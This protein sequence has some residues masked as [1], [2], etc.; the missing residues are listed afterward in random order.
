MQGPLMLKKIR[1]PIRFKILITLLGIISI[2]VG[3]ITFTMANLFHTDK[4][5]YVRD[6]TSI[7]ATNLAEESHSLLQSYR[8]RMVVFSR[9]VAQRDLPRNQKNLLVK[10]LFEDF[11][12][13][14][15]ISFYWKG[16]ELATAYDEI[17]L[18]AASL[19]RDDFVE[20]REANPVEE[21]MVSGNKVM[22]M[23]STLSNLLP[24]MN[25]GLSHPGPDGDGQMIVI[26]TIRLNKLIQITKRS[27]VF[28]T[29]IINSRKKFL[30]HSDPEEVVSHETMYWLPDNP[31]H[32]WWLIPGAGLS[33]P[34]R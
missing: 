26:A 33:R 27:E 21:Q 23:N 20:F 28:H 9:I 22:V 24:T 1:F 15:G 8:E 6:L 14:V 4:A 10:R 5:E 32:L 34:D 19:T 31:L 16:K 30:A 17:S 7:M 13:F 18:E 3:I 2:V 29:S 11:H 25:L 12:E